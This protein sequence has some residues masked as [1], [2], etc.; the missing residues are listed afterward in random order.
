[1]CKVD[2]APELNVFL[3]LVQVHP[4]VWKCGSHFRPPMFLW[5]CCM[6]ASQITVQETP[7]HLVRGQ[8]FLF[9]HAVPTKGRKRSQWRASR[10]E[11]TAFLSSPMLCMYLSLSVVYWI[12]TKF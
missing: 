11:T 4:I 3:L 7:Q 5:I 1:V 6:V 2:R 8:R 10:M 12:P 9:S